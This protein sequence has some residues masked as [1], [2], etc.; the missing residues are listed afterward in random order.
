MTNMILRR[1]ALSA[2]PCWLMLA[3]VYRAAR[4]IYRN[5]LPVMNQYILVPFIKETFS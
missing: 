3:D 2:P 1:Q 4:A 5:L